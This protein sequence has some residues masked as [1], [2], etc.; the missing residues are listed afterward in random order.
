MKKR[1]V[2]LKSLVALTL[3]SAMIVSAFLGTSNAEY[4]KTLKKKLD[5]EMTPDL[6]FAYRLYVNGASTTGV[7]K[8]TK[9]ISQK[10]TKSSSDRDFLKIKVS[11]QNHREQ[12]EKDRP[13]FFMQIH[14][15]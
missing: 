14:D 4:L 8:N 10:F 11:L 2:L 13:F 15:K 9:N 7:Y 6:D 3:L 5:L 12:S 1:N